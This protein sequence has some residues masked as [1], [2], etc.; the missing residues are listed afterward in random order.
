MIQ[1]TV[2]AHRSALDAGSVLSTLSGVIQ[3]GVQVLIWAGDA[4]TSLPPFRLYFW[5]LNAVL[6]YSSLIFVDWVC[7]TKGVQA[8][9][10]QLTFP[11]STAFNSTSLAPYTVG[12]VEY[13][14]FKTAD[15]LSFLNVFGAGHEVPAYQPVLALQAF[16]QTINQQPLSS[17]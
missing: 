7:N 17:T 1:S 15:K 2:L 5:P 13:G 10:S 9:V 6:T 14:T 12:G 3:S 4:G 16:T 8:V 11:G